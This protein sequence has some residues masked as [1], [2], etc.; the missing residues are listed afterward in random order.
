MI[1]IV[2]PAE[3]DVPQPGLVPQADHAVDQDAGVEH[4][5]GRKVCKCVFTAYPTNLHPVSQNFCKVFG[6]SACL[7]WRNQRSTWVGETIN[8]DAL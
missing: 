7:L 2:V 4:P 5:P 8:Y 3:P 6:S 1:R